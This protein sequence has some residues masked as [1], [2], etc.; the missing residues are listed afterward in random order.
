MDTENRTNVSVSSVMKAER[1][2]KKERGR[3]PGPNYQDPSKPRA[4]SKIPSWK[5]NLNDSDWEFGV[6]LVSGVT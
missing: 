2:M 3:L 6:S 5:T 4:S 1:K